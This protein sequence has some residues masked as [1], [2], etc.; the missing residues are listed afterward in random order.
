L[1]EETRPTDAYDGE[2]KTTAGYGMVDVTLTSAT[3]LVAGARVERFDQRVNTFDPFGF[4]NVRVSAENNNT[5]V[6]PAINLVH[7]LRSNTNLRFSYSTT[8]NRPEFRELAE[9]EF[10]DIVGNYAVKGNPDLNRALIQNF[11]GRWEVFNGTRGVVAAS[12][13]YKYFD[14]PIERIVVAGA[15]PL[16]TFQNADHATNFGFEFEGA[17]EMGRHFYVNANYA[18]VDSQV[19]LAEDQRSVQTSLERPLAG[20]SKNLFNVIGELSLANFSARLLFNYYGDRI[21]DVGANEAPDVVEQGRGSLDVVM[22]QRWRGLGIR[23]TLENLTDSDFLFT[24]SVGSL[25]ETQRR[26]KLGR[27]VGVSF[28]YSL[29]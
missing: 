11:D 15:Q 3:R 9:F 5:D 19:T 18:Y 4:S 28:S 6:F 14:D 2:Q 17:A 29:F 24:Q 7:A 23:L 27:T 12:A 22:S 21:A 13:F 8:V 25:H 10:T 26:Y 20:Q 1:T 16:A